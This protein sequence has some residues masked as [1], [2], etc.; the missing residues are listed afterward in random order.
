MR[1]CQS[2]VVDYCAKVWL[3]PLEL[4][5]TFKQHRLEARRASRAK[6]WERPTVGF[7]SQKCVSIGYINRNGHDMGERG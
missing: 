6:G 3:P 5:D 4:E 1:R 7:V 2:L